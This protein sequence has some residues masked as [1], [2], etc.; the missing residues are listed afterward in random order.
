MVTEDLVE[1]RC[2][3]LFARGRGYQGG[4]EVD[5]PGFI[6]IGVVIRCGLS[7]EFPWLGRAAARAAR[8]VVTA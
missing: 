1:R 5:D 6:G 2:G 3:V 4:I 8:M 7:G